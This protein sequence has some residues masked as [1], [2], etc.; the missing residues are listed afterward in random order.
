MAN[1]K[2]RLTPSTMS[3][4]ELLSYLSLS[5]QDV[6][7]VLSSKKYLGILVHS[8]SMVILRFIFFIEI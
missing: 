8:N 2:E 4:M 7:L 5:K 1:L 6:I 3:E